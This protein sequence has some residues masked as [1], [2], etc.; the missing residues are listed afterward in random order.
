[1]IL[2][3]EQKILN[4]E[5]CRKL[6]ENLDKLCKWNQD[7]KI[8]FNTKKYHMLEMWEWKEAKMGVWNGSWTNGLGKG[9]D[10]GVMVQDNLSLENLQTA[11]K[12]ESGLII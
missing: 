1:M 9:R 11:V 8:K 2:S 3:H 6:Q 4:F 10:L 12:Y 5:F 7:W